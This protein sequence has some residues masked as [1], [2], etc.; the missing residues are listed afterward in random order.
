LKLAEAL[1][2]SLRGDEIIELVGDLGSGKTAFVKG[3]A[4]GAGSKDKVTSPTFTLSQVY[5]AK[6]FQLHHFDFYRL[7]EPGIMATELAEVID[8]K[9]NVVIVEWANVAEKV[10]PKDRLT[11]KISATGENS[12]HFEFIYPEKLNYLIPKNT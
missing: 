6:N 4:R 5:K 8:D 11:I 1:G 9:N 2:S 7:G 12:R 3:V 10:L